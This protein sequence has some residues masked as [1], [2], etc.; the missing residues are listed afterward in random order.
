LFS[1]GGQG[2]LPGQL[3]YVASKGSIWRLTE[4]LAEELRGQEI[5]VNA[6]A[7]GMV[8]TKMTQ[9]MMAAGPQNIGERFFAQS[10]KKIAQGGDSPIEA[11]KL[12][13]FLLSERSGT[14]SGKILSAIWDPYNSFDL[15]Q[16]QQSDIYT[17]KRVIDSQGGTRFN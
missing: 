9:Q 16:L 6:I 2:A 3:A 8:D 10:Q 15:N 11:A 13:E 1:G 12:V 7:P 17:F 5:Y 14:L 4:T